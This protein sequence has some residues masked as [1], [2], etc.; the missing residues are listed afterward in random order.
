MAQRLTLAVSSV[1]WH[2]QQVYGKLGVSGK[3]QA[4]A[5]G[6]ALGL[7]DANSRESGAAPRPAQ[8]ALARRKHNLPQQLTNFIGREQPIAEARQLLRRSRLLTLTGP[9]GSGKT[10]LAQKIA[11]ETLDD[12]PD[13]VWLVELAP[14][15]DPAQVVSVV[16]NALPRLVKST[17]T[18]EA[19]PDG[20]SS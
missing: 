18:A 19:V 3:K 10:R 2:L 8:P 6:R 20:A 16:A 11:A 14:L 17:D 4:L 13:G 9:G 15:I 1:K 12:Y 5:R 7:L